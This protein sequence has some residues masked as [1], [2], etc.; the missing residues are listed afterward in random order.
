MRTF[1]SAMAFRMTA[2]EN[3]AVAALTQTG[4]SIWSSCLAIKSASAKPL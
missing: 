2:L 3:L 1:S 4:E